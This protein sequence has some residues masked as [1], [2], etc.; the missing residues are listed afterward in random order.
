MLDIELLH[1]IISLFFVR[2]SSFK[3]PGYMSWKNHFAV[4]YCVCHDIQC[5]PWG[6]SHW[7]WSSPLRQCY[8]LLCYTVICNTVLHC[9]GID[10]TVSVCETVV[11][12]C[13]VFVADGFAFSQEEHGAVLQVHFP[14]FIRFFSL[15][16]IIFTA[17]CMQCKARYCYRKSV[18]PSVRP[19]V[20]LMY[21][22]RVCWVSLKLITRIISL[23]SSLLRATTSA[24]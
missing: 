21:R 13:V 18:C 6:V 22:G 2:C 11:T 7:L 14:Q 23:G 19:S 4:Y 24:V 12:F 16:E 3:L 10:C 20:T 9:D 15:V 8:A 17:R 5:L 1:F